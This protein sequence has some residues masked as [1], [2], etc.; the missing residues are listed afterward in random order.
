METI[1][2]IDFTQDQEKTIK[3]AFNTE[4]LKDELSIKKQFD[5]YDFNFDDEWKF[6]YSAIYF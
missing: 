5:D 1:A 4:H 6:I 3:L 2:I